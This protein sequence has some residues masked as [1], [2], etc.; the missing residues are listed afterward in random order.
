M[1]NSAGGILA[2]GIVRGGRRIAWVVFWLMELLEV[3]EQA[4]K[5]LL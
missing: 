4:C 1:K 3:G 2:L 5:N